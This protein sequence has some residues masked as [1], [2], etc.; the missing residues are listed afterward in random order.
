M[1]E[2]RHPGSV[3]ARFVEVAGGSGSVRITGPGTV[4]SITRTDALGSKD[5]GEIDLSDAVPIGP[6]EILTLRVRLDR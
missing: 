4:R 5:R 1:P 2:E 3:L 6:G